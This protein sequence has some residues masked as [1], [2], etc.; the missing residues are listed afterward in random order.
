MR[1]K[2][3]CFALTH[4]GLVMGFNYVY[5]HIITNLPNILQS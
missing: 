1:D 5:V 3:G 4:V 2:S